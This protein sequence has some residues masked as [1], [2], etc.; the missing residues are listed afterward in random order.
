MVPTPKVHRWLPVGHRDGRIRDHAT[1]RG[2]ARL[3]DEPARLGCPLHG[4]R[5]LPGF[6]LPID[7]YWL[8]HRVLPVT[9]GARGHVVEILKPSGSKHMM[10][11]RG[12]MAE[13]GR[14]GVGERRQRLL[15]LLLL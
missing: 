2:R 1:V 6:D 10:R 7:G 11:G 12:G 9:V 8:I 3:L 13:D 15:L 4:R 5:G 14:L